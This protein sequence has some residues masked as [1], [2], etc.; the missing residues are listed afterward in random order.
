M[1]TRTRTP[2]I[3]W[4]TIRMLKAR[5]LASGGWFLFVTSNAAGYVAR[6]AMLLPDR[7]KA[8][9]VR[10]IEGREGK[11]VF[12]TYYR[13]NRERKLRWLAKAAGFEVETLDHFSSTAALARFLPIAVLELLWIRLLEKPALASLRSNLLGVLQVPPASHL[14]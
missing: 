1:K 11:D 12:P 4:T 14:R 8:P 7:V 13:A 3:P 6:S 9:L 10:V 5:V 2:K